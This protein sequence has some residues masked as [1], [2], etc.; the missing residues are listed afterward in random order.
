[1][2]SPLQ[3]ENFLGNAQVLEVFDI[4]KVGRVPAAASPKAWCR[5]GARV[6]IVRRDVVVRSWRVQSL[7][8][9]KDDVAEVTTAWNA[10]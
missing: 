3:R 10:A 7:R 1:M 2:L 6:R 9:F 4:H 5:R 8:R